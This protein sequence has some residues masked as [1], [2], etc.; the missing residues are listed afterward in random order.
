MLQT[1]EVHLWVVCTEGEQNHCTS[2]LKNGNKKRVSSTSVKVRPFPQWVNLGAGRG[3]TKFNSRKETSLVYVW[4]EWFVYLLLFLQVLEPCMN[5]SGRLLTHVSW[6][7]VGFVLH[8]RIE[9]VRR[10]GEQ[11]A[12]VSRVC[13]AEKTKN[14]TNKQTWLLNEFKTKKDFPNTSC[15][16]SS[17]VNC[18]SSEQSLKGC[19]CESLT[20]VKDKVMAMLVHVWR[21]RDDFVS[22]FQHMEC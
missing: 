3:K 2:S 15:Q 12:G 17:W 10:H 8:Q 9:G 16:Q 18:V 19:M 5:V 13:P 11:V 7:G 21:I 4:Q 6:D 22:T 14:N 1:H 20:R